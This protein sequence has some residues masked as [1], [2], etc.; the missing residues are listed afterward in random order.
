MSRKNPQSGVLIL[1]WEKWSKCG[2]YP[3]PSLVAGKQKYE[4]MV[5]IS[6]QQFLSYKRKNNAYIYCL[7]DKTCI[8]EIK[9]QQRDDI[10]CIFLCPMENIEY[11]G[12]T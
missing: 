9:T 3:I 2:K 7:K 1:S 5:N 4:M 10:Q 6:N 11:N 8:N 12:A